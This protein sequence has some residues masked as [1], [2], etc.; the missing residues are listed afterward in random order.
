MVERKEIKLEDLLEAQSKVVILATVEAIPE[1]AESVKITP[2]VPGRGCACQ[3][4]LVVPK[5]AIGRLVLT[6]ERH[7]CCGKVLR[8]VEV[9]FREGSTLPIADVFGDISRRAASA[10]PARSNTAGSHRR[11]TRPRP[12]FRDLVDG[13]L[14]FML[15]DGD[16]GTGWTGGDGDGSGGDDGDD[17]DDGSSRLTWDTCMADCMKQNTQIR[18]PA[19]RRRACVSLC[20]PIVDRPPIA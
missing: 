11:R 14:G 4:A 19:E 15:G 20:G 8:V 16:D 13:R 3:Y 9:E 6:E 17:G 18:D 12:R 7:H 1:S 2:W 5:H 10:L